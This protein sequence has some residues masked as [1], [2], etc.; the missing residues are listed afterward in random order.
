MYSGVLV[1]CVFNKVFT[2]RSR[3]LYDWTAYIKLIVLIIVRSI[4]AA[5]ALLLPSRGYPVT[6]TQ[7]HT[8]THRVTY[9]HTDT[10][11]HTHS[12]NHSH[13][14]SHTL[15]YTS[16]VSKTHTLTRHTHT[17]RHGRS[18]QTNDRRIDQ[19]WRHLTSSL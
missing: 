18:E 6:H 10:N 16:T 19:F 2:L 11:T 17:L 3:R 4:Y 1:I 15:T 14:H 9:P 7:S 12:H 8:V 5:A 13:T